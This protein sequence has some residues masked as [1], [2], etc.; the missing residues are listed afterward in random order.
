MKYAAVLLALVLAFA[1]VAYADVPVGD[2]APPV[3][4]VAGKQVPLPGGDWVIAGRASG[5]LVRGSGLGGYGA[6]ENLVLFRIASS[7]RVDAM[8]EI[9]TNSLSV[10]DGWGI[11]GDCQRRDLMLAVVRSRSGW[12]AACFFVTHTAWEVGG[13]PVDVPAAWLEAKAFAAKRRLDL[14]A[15]TVTAGFRVANRRDVIDVRFH[16]SVVAPS[17]DSRDQRSLAFDRDIAE[18]SAMMIGCVEAGLKNRLQA[19]VAIPGPDASAAVLERS[20]IQHQRQE[21]IAYLRSSGL[22]S[23]EQ[24]DREMAMLREAEADDRHDA[25][26]PGEAHFYRL[27]SLQGMSVT[28]D[29]LVTFLWTAQSVQAAALTM[30]QAGFRAGRSYVASYLWDLYGGAPTRPDFARTVDFAYGGADR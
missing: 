27:L 25:I 28:S 29:A 8:A 22:L 12:D 10:V 1:R 13:V 2:S 23:A 14:P 24:F 16:F 4:S 20:T 7:G 18:W 15:N 19:S 26:D 30:M 3:L 6:I 17:A 9:N 21:R 5:T 11:A